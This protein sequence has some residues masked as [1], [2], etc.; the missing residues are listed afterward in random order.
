M[1]STLK[2][3]FEALVDERVNGRSPSRPTGDK[4]KCELYLYVR[5][6]G[7]IPTQV[8]WSQTAE[9]AMREFKNSNR[10]SVDGYTCLVSFEATAGA[11]VL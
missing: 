7:G 5:L 8:A 6:V 3:K 1:D 9:G 2:F 4:E 11:G 10:E